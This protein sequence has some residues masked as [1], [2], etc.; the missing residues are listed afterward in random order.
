VSTHHPLRV[1]HIVRK[2]NPLEWGGTETYVA[3]V[4]SALR[5]E[6]WQSEVHA[7]SCEADA[8]DSGL[9]PSVALRRFTALNPYI[10][11]TERRAGLRS[12]GGNLVT[13][14]E[15]LR[16]LRDDTL[17]IAHLH[18]AGRIGGAVRFAM[19]VRRRPYVLSVHGPLLSDPALVARETQHR[20]GRAIDVGAPVGALF[21]AR[22]VL[23]DADAILCFNEAERRALEARYG[24][25]VQRMDHGVD[26]ARYS[27]GEA[28]RAD[29]RWPQ[30]RGKRVLLVLGRVS[31]QKNQRF[32]VEA[33]AASARRDAVLALAGAET[34]PGY[35]DETLALAARLGLADRVFAL[36]NVPRTDVVAL[37]ARADALLVPS[38]HEAFGLVVLE[39]WAA[40]KPVLFADSVGLEE[41]SAP[42]VDR[43][44]CLRAGAVS[45]WGSAIDGLLD[46]P[47]RAR[48]WA[49][50]G[51]ALCERRFSWEA[52]ASRLA[53]VYRRAIERRAKHNE[54][55]AA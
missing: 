32:A 6:R 45:D 13:L 2:W 36:G 41:L 9:D 50:E 16:L 34:D 27:T 4:T 20:R 48:S 37:L 5:N 33:L 29:A 26:V 11:S 51:R 44:V 28:M 19:R 8:C 15:P 54:R 31:R 53:A 40:R 38:T 46:D 24:A 35:L 47:E 30:L 10:A 18:T 23:D 22:R 17:S 12:V 7:P 21:G 14:D 49:E 3:S 55:R 43:S 1:A 42:L 25:R 52:V 39:G